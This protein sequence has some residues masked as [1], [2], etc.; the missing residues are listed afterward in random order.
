MSDVI[1]VTPKHIR[2]ANLCSRGAR[3]W[4]QLHKL[5]FNVFITKGYPVEVIEAT[6]DALGTL[7]ANLARADAAGDG[8]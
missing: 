7:V 1:M 6:N 8:E 5:D 4:F 3:Q 2:Q